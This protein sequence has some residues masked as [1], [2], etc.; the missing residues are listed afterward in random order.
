MSFFWRFSRKIPDL[1]FARNAFA[2][3][4]KAPGISN[5]R[6]ESLKYATNYQAIVCIRRVST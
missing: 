4:Q 5:R 3:V 1:L 6:S 2:R